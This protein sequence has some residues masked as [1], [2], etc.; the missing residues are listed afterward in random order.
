ML[1]AGSGLRSVRPLVAA[2]AE[3]RKRHT[4]LA[5]RDGTRVAEYI[6]YVEKGVNA[7]PDSTSTRARPLAVVQLP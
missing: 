4:L 6:L 2:G 7:R 3:G 5:L 1:P